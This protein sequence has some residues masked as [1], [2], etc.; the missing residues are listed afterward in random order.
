MATYS[1]LPKITS[2]KKHG[3]GNIKAVLGIIIAIAII[4]FMLIVS[5]ALRLTSDELRL[6]EAVITNAFTDIFEVIYSG[7]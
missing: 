7:C 3:I 6:T 1:Q 5:V 4:L 2:V